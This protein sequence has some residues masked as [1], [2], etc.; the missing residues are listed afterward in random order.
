M[1][2]IEGS[3]KPTESACDAAF[4]ADAGTIAPL[5]LTCFELRKTGFEFFVPSD[6]SINF[7]SSGPNSAARRATVLLRLGVL[8]TFW[9]AILSS[10]SYNLSIFSFTVPSSAGCS[11]DASKMRTEREPFTLCGCRRRRPHCTKDLQLLSGTPPTECGLSRHDTE[12]AIGVSETLTKPSD[13]R[14]SGQ[15]V[16]LINR[17]LDVSVHR[18]QPAAGRPHSSVRVSTLLK[19]SSLFVLILTFC[20]R[21]GD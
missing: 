5:Q 16:T 11:D 18:S 20:A 3:R 7:L 9:P 14:T 12:I 15:A 21:L 2:V 4:F 17:G 1:F 8:Q 10:A 19:S 6:G 13:G